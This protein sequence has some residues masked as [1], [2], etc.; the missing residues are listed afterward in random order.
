MTPLERR[1]KRLSRLD[2]SALE[3]VARAHSRLE[4]RASGTE[5]FAEGAE[6]SATYAVVGGWCVRTRTLADGRRQVLGFVLPGDF[7]HFSWLPRS[8]VATDVECCTPVSLANLSQVRRHLLAAHPDD[9]LAVAFRII[10]EVDAAQ[11]HVHVA[12]LGRQSAY[13]RIAVL[14][15]DLY[16]RL[17]AVGLAGEEGFTMPLT[18]QVL[19][20]ALGLSI[21]HVNRTLMQL[22][23][24]DLIVRKGQTIRLPDRARLASLVDYNPPAILRGEARTEGCVGAD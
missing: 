2:G 15:L 23:R 18:Q 12:M 10:Q 7:V 1:L 16:R 13:E 3:L 21:V 17:E 20:E 8:M 4:T 9:P 19:A 6:P 11:Q 5:L 14:M 24:D 22:G